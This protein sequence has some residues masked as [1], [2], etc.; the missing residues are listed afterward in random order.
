MEAENNINEAEEILSTELAY[1]NGE[2]R[3]KSLLRLGL[4]VHLPTRTWHAGWTK[5]ESVTG[6]E[7]FIEVADPCD[8]IRER[9]LENNKRLL[10]K[11]EWP[12]MGCTL[13]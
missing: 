8:M 13:I 11:K 2:G 7:V 10:A 12:G 1:S 3:G 5:S 9:K 6:R 4:E